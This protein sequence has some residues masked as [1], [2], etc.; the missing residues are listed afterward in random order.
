MF[1]TEIMFKTWKLFI[2]LVTPPPITFHKYYVPLN[3]SRLYVIEFLKIQLKDFFHSIS[4][5][6]PNIHSI[7]H[8]DM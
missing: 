7:R 1:K 2:Q 5:E 3:F 4:Y 6:L 8:F